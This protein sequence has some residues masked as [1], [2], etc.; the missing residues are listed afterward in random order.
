MLSLNLPTDR[1]LNKEETIKSYAHRLP[2]QNAQN[3]A[4]LFR[5]SPAHS[6]TKRRR[7]KPAAS[8]D[9]SRKRG[10][11]VLLRL[12]LRLRRVSR[13]MAKSG[14]GLDSESVA[15]ATVLK[16]AVELDSESRY[17]QA[18]VCYQEGIDLLLQVLKGEQ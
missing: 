2:S 3:V 18:L 12:G 6:R 16:R 7:N 1:K 13:I 8:R 4:L 10:R 9:R 15:A 5:L 14:R 17:Q 11:P